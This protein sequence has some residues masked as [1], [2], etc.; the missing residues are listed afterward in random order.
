MA[1]APGDR[2][3]L[4]RQRGEATT[5]DED[6]DERTEDDG[7]SASGDEDEGKINDPLTQSDADRPQKPWGMK[8]SSSE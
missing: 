5:A 2:T 7:T 8:Q 3:S 6:D 1:G 4:H